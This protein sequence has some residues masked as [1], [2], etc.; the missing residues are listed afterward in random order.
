MYYAAGAKPNPTCIFIICMILASSVEAAKVT[1][2]LKFDFTADH[3]ITSVKADLTDPDG[4]IQAFRKKV[5]L[6]KNPYMKYPEAENMTWVIA[7]FLGCILLFGLFAAK[8][9]PME[10]EDDT[11]KEPLLQ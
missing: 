4:A 5:A 3:N 7:G 6:Q 2:Y 9:L 10:L 8:P 1:L 11:G